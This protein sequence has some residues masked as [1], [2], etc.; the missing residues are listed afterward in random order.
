MAS[1]KKGQLAL[2]RLGFRA[3]LL[4]EIFHETSDL[5]P[6]HPVEILDD[7]L[8]DLE[9]LGDVVVSDQGFR[10]GQFLVFVAGG[11]GEVSDQLVLRRVHI[12]LML[13]SLISSLGCLIFR[14]NTRLP[15]ELKRTPHLRCSQV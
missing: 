7:L 1:S 8:A 9:N 11:I 6:D 15:L 12:D 10:Q 13:H 5:L 4:D 14:K 2:G 3:V